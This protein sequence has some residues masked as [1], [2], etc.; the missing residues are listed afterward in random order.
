M[1]TVSTLEGTV[2]H[3]PRTDAEWLQVRLRALQLAEAANLLMIPGR[4]VGHPGQQA[5]DLGTP[6]YLS[7]AQAQ[8]AIDAERDIFLAYAAALRD[9]AV[10]AVSAVDQRNLDEFL[11]VGGQIDEACEQCHQKFWYP[12]AAPPPLAMR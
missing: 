1:A 9:T 2:E 12:G 6:G 7:I 10:R 3:Q 5:D 4:Q 11:E 8:S